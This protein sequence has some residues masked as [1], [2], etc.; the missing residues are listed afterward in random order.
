M[1]GLRVGVQERDCLLG[2][3][4]SRMVRDRMLEQS[5]DY[6][7]WVC[8]ICG[9]PAVVDKKRNIKECRVCGLN[10]VVLVRLPYGT[11]MIL[12]ELMGMNLV[13]RLMTTQHE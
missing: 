4:A 8:K 6:Q 10:Q 12:Q 9:L 13:P 2:Q 7:M 5:D 11:K 3:G 1:G